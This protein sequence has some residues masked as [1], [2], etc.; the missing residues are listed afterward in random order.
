MASECGHLYADQRRHPKSCWRDALPGEE[1]HADEMCIEVSWRP[2][3]SIFMHMRGAIRHPVGAT[4]FR[5]RK[6]MQIKNDIRVLIGGSGGKA[7]SACKCK[8]RD[9][10]P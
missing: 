5:G 7:I 4:S 1:T 2:G 10:F 9:R 6:H 3:A 8:A